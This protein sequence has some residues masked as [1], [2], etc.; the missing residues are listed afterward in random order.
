MLS[1]EKIQKKV[2][3]LSALN[4]SLGEPQ[5]TESLSDGQG[6]ASH[7]DHQVSIYFHPDT[8]AH[9]ISG[10]IL[11][12]WQE[13]GEESGPLGYPI[14]DTSL[15]SDRVGQFSHFQNGSIYWSPQTGAHE[16]R[17]AIRARWAELGSE[18][19]ALGYPVSG[20]RKTPDQTGFYNDF[21][22]GRITWTPEYGARESHGKPG[23][24]RARVTPRQQVISA[25][26]FSLV[27]NSGFYLTPVNQHLSVDPQPTPILNIVNQPVVAVKPPAENVFVPE[28]PVAVVNPVF[29]EV[30]LKPERPLVSDALVQPIGSV[31]DGVIPVKPLP[32]NEQVTFYPV[33][34]HIYDRVLLN[35]ELVNI[36]GSLQPPMNG[37]P[38]NQLTVPVSPSEVVNDTLLFE[39][40][41]DANQKY[42]LPRY[43]VQKDA[44]NAVQVFFRK[45]DQGAEL[46]VRLEKYA[47][48]EI[49]LDARNAGELPH[50]I[51]VL[52]QFRV[53][54]QGGNG[55]GVQME[56]PFQLVNPTSGYVD[57]VLHMSTEAERNA[58]FA[59]MTQEASGTTLVI[60]RL[61][62]VAVPLPPSPA[63]QPPLPLRP[64]LVNVIHK[65]VFDNP[66]L[67]HMGFMNKPIFRGWVA[68]DASTQTGYQVVE[69]TLDSANQSF[70][71][72]RELYPHVYLDL[73]A[74]EQPVLVRRQVNGHSY[75]HYPNDRHF[76]YLPDR[77][78]LA[79]TLP[80]HTPGMRVQFSGTSMLD[81]RVALTYFA[82]PDYDLERIRAAVTELK[83]NYLTG[84]PEDLREPE[85]E[86]LTG[87]ASHRL[88]L[89]LPGV[90]SGILQDRPDALVIFAADGKGISDAITDM[91]EAQFQSLFDGLMDASGN[92]TLF[93]GELILDAGD[94]IQNRIPFEGRLN[95]LIGTVI[96]W[97]GVPD[98]IARGIR[99]TIRN[100]IES[101]IRI[102]RQVVTGL[103]NPQFFPG[104]T[105]AQIADITFPFELK[106]GEEK[107]FL[108]SFV[109]VGSS[110]DDVPYDN[111]VVVIDQQQV[112]VLPDKEAILSAIIDP[113]VPALPYENITVKTLNKDIF[114]TPPE[115]PVMALVIDF[116]NGLDVD[117][118]SD[119]LEAASALYQPTADY[120][121]RKPRPTEYRYQ[122]MTI[123]KNGQ[124]TE[125]TWLTAPATRTLLYV[126][127][128]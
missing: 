77:I 18:R 99:T 44:G 64:D 66:A 63:S 30:V 49:E 59:A 23:A 94:G 73:P 16:I 42:F 112:E 51:Q 126:S 123:R 62:K 109:E 57:A 88:R 96:D 52:L 48:P 81:L 25:N 72:P 22:R 58:V 14:S 111:W 76:Y 87:F 5:R 92:A 8:D 117:L 71:Y 106:P 85:F 17:A 40:P 13:L 67:N 12:R 89:T 10:P 7:Y 35:P 31:V 33:Q 6:I 21:Q 60:R 91:T 114:T 38:R 4:W 70:Y 98:N 28:Q 54:V 127:A 39:A 43:R 46:R 113:R 122:V 3:E 128:G 82:S 11:A 2:D 120:L 56:K 118:L 97:Q 74:G 119:K 125:S 103:Y 95:D 124:S 90:A 50:Q 65:P 27:E 108:V 78:K 115:N 45:T 24:I 100:V 116:E 93:Q 15:T 101:P 37:T 80:L 20:K 1:A 41:N 36:V 75:Y 102:E 84:L 47:A 61:F 86:A 68:R 105:E 53:S 104:V 19:S 34:P 83:N 121:L 26:N 9:V 29:N 69:R 55:S 79:R 107:S 110:F 32:V